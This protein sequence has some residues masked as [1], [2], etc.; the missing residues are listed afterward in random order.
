[1]LKSQPITESVLE[2]KCQNCGNAEAT[3]FIVLP[4]TDKTVALCSTCD[5]EMARAAR[6]DI[7]DRLEKQPPHPGKKAIYQPVDELPECSDWEIV[8]PDSRARADL[9]LRMVDETG[10]IQSATAPPPTYLDIGCNTGYFCDRMRRAGFFSEGVD[11][12]KGDIA[13][14]KA[15]DSYFRKGHSRYLAQDAYAYL[16]ETQERLF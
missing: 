15:L 13:V 5:E 10:V 4:E 14:A 2:M 11:V 6:L 1:M 16:Q 8:R 3:T 9:M 12:V 7:L